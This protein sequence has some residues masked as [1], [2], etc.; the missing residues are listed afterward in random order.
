MSGT[1]VHS[2]KQKK[3]AIQYNGGMQLPLKF[4]AN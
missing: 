2:V 4:H 3:I 1:V